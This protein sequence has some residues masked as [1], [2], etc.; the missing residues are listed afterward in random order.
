MT[1][2]LSKSIF[3]IKKILKDGNWFRDNHGRY[4]I[5]R[6][7]N[8]G[9]RSKL[10]PYIPIVSLNIHD[11]NEVDLQKEISLVE[12]NLDHLKDLGFNVIRL[13]IMWKAIEPFPN[14]HL[15]E[16]LPEGKNYLDMIK[17][18]IDTLHERRLFVI[19]DFH[20]DIAHE[21]YGGDG[22]PDWALAIDELHWKPVFPLSEIQK[23]TWYLSYYINHF[24]KH[25]LRSFW[26]NSLRN[27]EFGLENYPVRTHL[28]KT[29][30]QTIKYFNQLYNDS[31][32]PVIIGIEPFNEPHQ[33]GLEIRDFESRVLREFYINVINEIKKFDDKIFIFMEPRTDWNIYTSPFSA[34]IVDRTEPISE[35][36]ELDIDKNVIFNQNEIFTFLPTDNEF[37]DYFKKQGV[38]SF[39]YYDPQTLSNSLINRPDDMKKKNCNGHNFF[40]R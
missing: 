31:N 39:H 10:S 20:Q 2:I 11:I 37:L 33:V 15:D 26:N 1:I 29:I 32:G 7:V 23:R 35:Q 25:T 19:L 12:K 8:F 22:F 21:V 38:F 16:L 30:G 28:E 40:R 14:Q 4:L 18:I 9:S 17:I 13:L 6:G 34:S 5:F 24:V 3:D 27:I 36:I